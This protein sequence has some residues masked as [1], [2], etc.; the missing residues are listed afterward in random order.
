MQAGDEQQPPPHRSAHLR[1]ELRLP[2]LVL[3]Q[4]LYIAAYSWLGVAGRVGSPHIV[5]WLPAMLL[6]YIPSGIV[7]V[8]LNQQMPIEGGLYQWAKLRFGN[9]AGFLVALNIW[10]AMVLL[11]SSSIPSIAQVFT[12]TTGSLH[13]LPQTAWF[14][15]V[16]AIVMIALLVFISLRGLELGKWIHNIGGALT[17]AIFAAIILAAIPRWIH[18][19]FAITPVSFA[20]PAASLLNLNLLGKMGFG[21]FCGLDGNSIFA[22]ECR[23]PNVAR[24][25]RRSVF[26]SGPLIAAVYVLGTASVLTFTTPAQIDMIAPPLQVLQHAASSKII[27]TLALIA[28]GLSMAS[29]TSI[30]YNIAVRLPM[31]AGWDHLLPR[32]LCRLHPRYRTPAGSI[33]L[34][35]AVALVLTILGGLGVGAQEAYQSTFNAGLICW[36][37]T[38]VVMFLIPL[39]GKGERPPLTVITACISGLLMTLLYAVL[40]IFPII[41]VA[42]PASFT[43]KVGGIVAAVNL[44]GT[45]YYAWRTRRRNALQ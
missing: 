16:L 24:A 32:W 35:G 8:Y 17:I 42:N 14:N 29:Y 20:L 1:K 9:L 27:M 12:Y 18:G 10:I 11:V 2:D 36:S 26:V 37:L 28:F 39:L 41:D 22:E 4:V 38:Y 25:L 7:V 31:V 23:D 3:S 34:I 21:A 19:S 40:S 45:L 15:P 30:C 33:F 43:L 5:F 44:A 13:T 6:F